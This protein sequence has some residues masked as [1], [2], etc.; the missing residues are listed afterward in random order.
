MTE[1]NVIEAAWSIDAAGSWLK[2]KT[3]LTGQAQAV[4]GGMETGKK[5]T[6]TIKEWRR[7]RSLDASAYLWTLVNKLAVKVGAPPKE[8]YRHYIPDVGENSDIVCVRDEAVQKFRD[9]WEG[10]GIGWC[11]DILPSKIS[12]CTNVVCYYGSSTYDT[13]QMA[14]LIEL[15][16]ADCKAQGIETLTPEELERMT[17]GWRGDAEGNESNQNPGQG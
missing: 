16:V 5:Y 3:E 7:K 8:L 1:L 17:L 9:A 2:L 11:T 13:K 12:G 15:V 4:A 6:V 14:R 10:N